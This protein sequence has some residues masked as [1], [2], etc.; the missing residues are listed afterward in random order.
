MSAYSNLDTN[1]LTENISGGN[2]VGRGGVC[3]EKT[4]KFFVSCRKN[5]SQD[6]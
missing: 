1:T 2:V 5:P 6:M 4:F 3:D